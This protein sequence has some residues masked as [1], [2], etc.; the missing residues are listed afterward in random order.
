MKH[1]KR[2]VKHLLPVPVGQLDGI[3]VES[4]G[5]MVVSKGYANAVESLVRADQ[6]GVFHLQLKELQRVVLNLSGPAIISLSGASTPHS[7]SFF[8]PALSILLSTSFA[9]STTSCGA[10]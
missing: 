1:Y 5:R 8:S 10:L 6:K 9:T 7:F 3:P 4:F 2:C